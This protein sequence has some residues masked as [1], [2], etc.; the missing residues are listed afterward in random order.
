MTEF[1]MP[2]IMPPCSPEVE[3]SLIGAVL[4]DPECM[5]DI[6]LDPDEFYIDR[7]RWIYSTCQEL[8]STGANIDIL[9]VSERLKEL[10][11]LGEV[12][13]NAR[14]TKII[15]NCPT[16]QH[17]RDYAAII[18][19]DARRRT[20][21]AISSQIAVRAYDKSTSF[22]D[23]I[24]DGIDRLSRL[25]LAE[26]SAV[27]WNHYLSLL[28]DEIEAAYKN[29]KET[30]GIPTG[31]YD[32]DAITGGL[33]RG[34]EV[35][36]SG[37][38]GVGKSILAM[39]MVIHAASKGHPGACYH[40]EMRGASI[41]RRAISA[42]SGVTTRIMRTGKLSAEDW[43]KVTSAIETCGTL[44]I[45]MSDSPA[46]NTASLRVD[47]ERQ[48]ALHRIEW[49]LIDYEGLLTDDPD[50]GEIERSKIIS[51]RLHGI[52]KDLNLA[53]LV[54]NDMNKEGIKKGD[55]G[56]ASLAGSARS[57]HDA[58]SIWILK[59]D[60]EMPNVVKLI[61]EKLREGDTGKSRVLELYKSTNP[62]LPEFKNPIKQAGRIQL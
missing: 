5:R 25:S 20:A 60:K 10:N 17:A 57:L 45:Y 18:R 1:T 11:R 43:E 40:L 12:G 41:A 62:A 34:E 26:Q 55:G 19:D 16:S 9:T 14:L 32:Y 30:F 44:P 38:P 47:I 23:F 31:I 22:N 50:R 53:G 4:I 59:Q 29:P 3:E 27:H 49:V 61:S 51:S 37:E 21:L 56:Q 54:I 58:D 35:K 39:Q 28:Y 48:I 15:E 7:N 6:D 33:I 42:W 8:R 52:I 24:P 2:D 36:L 13:G 46:W